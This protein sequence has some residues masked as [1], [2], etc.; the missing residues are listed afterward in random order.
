MESELNE[1]K[2]TKL[3]F[4]E[5]WPRNRCRATDVTGAL[6]IPGLAATGLLIHIIPANSVGF[7]DSGRNLALSPHSTIYYR[8]LGQP[9]SFPLNLSFLKSI[10]RIKTAWGIVL[11]QKYNDKH[12]SGLL[13]KH[14]LYLC[15][16][17]TVSAIVEQVLRWGRNWVKTPGFKFWINY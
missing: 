8:I 13:Y 17:L 1:K 16:C 2:F 15:T 14:G 12:S 11:K 9:F 5:N 7:S 10:I 3:K 4:G 6:L